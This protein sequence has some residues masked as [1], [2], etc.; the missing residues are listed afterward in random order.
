MCVLCARVCVIVCVRAAKGAPG[1]QRN[2]CLSRTQNTHIQTHTHTHNAHAPAGGR[3]A[4]CLLPPAG[5]P[6]ACR[7]RQPTAPHPP[8]P[9]PAPGP[10]QQRPAA[11]H[12]AT[13]QQQNTISSRGRRR[14]CVTGA[15]VVL[16]LQRRRTQPVAQ[17]QDRQV[18]GG[19]VAVVVQA[20]LSCIAQ[21]D[22]A[23]ACARRAA[24]ST[25]L[26]GRSTAAPGR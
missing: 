19:V 5:A 15:S 8:A 6:P 3:P 10:Q 1:T 26:K 24:V 17:T 2:V 7:P 18:S 25:G 20:A 9:P 14:Q 22:G 11:R 12:K 13:A 16:S 21:L 4:S 23:P